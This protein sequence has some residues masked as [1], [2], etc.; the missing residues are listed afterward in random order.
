MPTGKA[1]N[2]KTPEPRPTRAVYWDTCVFIAWLK[3][4]KRKSGDM[5]GLQEVATEIH[6]NKIVL[7]T[8][9]LTRAELLECNLPKGA[10][11]KYN[12]LF[13]RSNVLEIP[14][15]REVAELTSEIR[16]FYNPGD[17]ELLTPDAMHLATAISFDAFEFHTFDGSDPK[18]KPRNL[19]KTCCG[20][21]V[22]NGS[23]A[24]RPLTIRKPVGQQGDL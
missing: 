12:K 20:L 3:N 18:K 19:K 4:E 14:F 6:K 22:L 7:I 16:N 21:L 15:D 5:E 11:E 2:K 9:T 8:S 1:G 23:V 17:F 24:N 13:R 10:I